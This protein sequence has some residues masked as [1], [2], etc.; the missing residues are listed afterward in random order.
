MENR[1]NVKVHPDIQT[2]N[3][4][5]DKFPP[6]TFI[7]GYRT[8]LFIDGKYVLKYKVSMLVRKDGEQ[9]PTYT[10]SRYMRFGFLPTKTQEDFYSVAYHCYQSAII[11]F[12]KS[13]DSVFGRDRFMDTRFETFEEI[14]KLID[15]ALNPRVN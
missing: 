8:N 14:K 2:D 3:N 1:V 15:A 9:N 10:Y 11:E 12:N 4:I 7:I 6:E 13:L 5:P